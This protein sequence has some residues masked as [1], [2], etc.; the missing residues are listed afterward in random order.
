MNL[1]ENVKE[2]SF[3]LFED[4]TFLEFYCFKK[5]LNKKDFYNKNYTLNKNKIKKTFS[6]EMIKDFLKEYNK[7]I[8]FI[9][10]PTLNNVLSGIIVNQ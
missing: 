8:E 1:I 5:N 3:N 6:I 4:M 7:K 2:L 10:L 9:G